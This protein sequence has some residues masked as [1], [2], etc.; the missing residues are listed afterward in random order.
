MLKNK[1]LL[2]ILFIIFFLI[3]E[4]ANSLEVYH[5]NSKK[6]G[7]NVLLI[8]GTHGNE[9]AGTNGLLE[10]IDN[11][12]KGELSLKSGSIT[13]IPKANRFGLLLGIRWL[14]HHI[15]NRDL[16]RNYPHKHGDKPLDVLSKKICVYIRK[17]DFIVDFHEGWGFH[18]M[19]NKS[20]G[21]GL[22]PGNSKKSVKIA[23]QTLTALNKSINEPKKK[24]VLKTRINIDLKTLKEYANLLEKDYIL[25][26]TSGQN[27]IQPMNVRLDQIR[28][29][30]HN[31]LTI[32]EVI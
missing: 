16:N 2:I 23:K 29:I 4:W 14:P 31:V 17:A 6:S 13:I 10:L 7:K 3:N 28:I 22:Y 21:S 30:L 1:E 25:V 15:F 26:E 12:E 32:L 19:N 20:M 11:L 9:P 24:F 27:N 5:F 8:A 18:L